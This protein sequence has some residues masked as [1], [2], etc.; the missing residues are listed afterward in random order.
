MGAMVT[1][2]KIGG[3]ALGFLGLLVTLLDALGK[4]R[5]QERLDFARLLRESTQGLPRSTPGFDKFLSAFPAPVGIE[6]SA[7]ISTAKDVLQTHDQFPISIT[8]RYVAN[9]QR[10][11]PVATYAEVVA[12]SEKTRQK[13]WS[14]SISAVGWVMLA[15]AFAIEASSTP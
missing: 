13:W 11:A 1:T 3:L 4:F 14:L 9:G 15:S 2:L 10:T 6:A 5:D 8:V 12:W 7:I